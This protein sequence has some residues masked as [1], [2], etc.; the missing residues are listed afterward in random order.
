MTKQN[1]NSLY[2]YIR[3]QC[4]LVNRANNPTAEWRAVN[5]A[6]NP[7]AE[8]RAVMLHGIYKAAY[9]YVRDGGK[10]D[11]DGLL[12][13]LSSSAIDRSDSSAQD[14]TE[15]ENKLIEWDDGN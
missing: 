7:T 14:L 5:R 11:L 13:S 6:N 3:S 1:L 12:S 8:W 10:R 9:E 2:D 4:D 15:Y